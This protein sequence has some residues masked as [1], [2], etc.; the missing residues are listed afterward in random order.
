MSQ[1]AQGLILIVDDI[2]QNLQILR[3]ALSKEG[4]RVAAANNGEVALKY[5]E[6]NRP[7]LILLDVMMP[8]MNGLQVSQQL[9]QDPELSQIPIIF[10]T[11]R[12]EKEDILAGFEAGGVDYISKPFHMAELLSRVKTHLSLKHT[13]DALKQSN[14]ELTDLLNEKSELM[15]IASH[16]LKNPL[17]VILMHAQ[18]LENQLQ[19]SQQHQVKAILE[20]GRRMLDILG[21]LLDMQ[22][23]ESGRIVP[24]PVLIDLND[25]LA[26]LHREYLPKAQH[27]A[28]AF[29]LE[30]PQALMFTESDEFLLRQILDN[31][32]SN[33][34]KYTPAQREVRIRLLKNDGIAEIQI[35][36]QGPGFTEQDRSKMFQKFAKLSA[37]PTAGEH[38]TG[39]GLSIVKT[40]C[41]LLNLELQFESSS[42]GSQFKLLLPLMDLEM[43]EFEG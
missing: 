30:T 23:V 38:S 3:T 39:L 7:D 24:Q 32:I 40:L 26:Y 28:I 17:T 8:A 18:T 13:Q 22:S 10:L 4:Y 25:T 31:L 35:L 12:S 5:L 42:A 36:D 41:Q 16:D 15:A 14:A 20:S 29:Q 21:K 33:A 11:A 6:K 9:K 37:K 34:L 27:K 43:S 19:D 1:S 2:P